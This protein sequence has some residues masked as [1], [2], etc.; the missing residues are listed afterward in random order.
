MNGEA[1]RKEYEM[2]EVVRSKINRVGK[3]EEEKGI[4]AKNTKKLNGKGNI[5]REKM[6]QR[7]GEKVSRG[8]GRE[9]RK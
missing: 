4:N 2:V 3:E 1:A 8:K 6:G 7:R 9:M 5:F